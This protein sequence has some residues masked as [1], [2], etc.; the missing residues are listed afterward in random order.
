LDFTTG[1]PRSTHDNLEDALGRSMYPDEARA[2]FG[3]HTTAASTSGRFD[4][5]GLIPGITCEACHGPG[6]Q[7]VVAMSAGT[8]DY[9]DPQITNLSRLSPVDSVDFCGACHR[10]SADTELAGFKGVITLRF[11]PYRLESSRCWREPDARL[12]C[13]A[14]HDPHQALVKNA[15]AYDSRCLSCHVSN[16]SSKVNKDHPGKACRV[17]QNNC[18]TCH[19]PKINIP[20]MHA[21]FTDHRIGIHR[22]GEGFVN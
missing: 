7:H 13:V 1:N 19:M 8:G 2:C 11:P 16:A 10:T 14:C 4:P 15:A 12:T 6:L 5:S 3:C 9:V 22:P 17:S 20:E 18:T 21:S